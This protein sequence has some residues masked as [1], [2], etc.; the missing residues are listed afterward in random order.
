MRTEH[1]QIYFCM[2]IFF[3]LMIAAGVALDSSPRQL[4][5][6][7]GSNMDFDV[8]AS[9][10]VG[11][12]DNWICW[13]NLSDSMNHIYLQDLSSLTTTPV[14]VVSDSQKLAHPTIARSRHGIHIIWERHE[15]ESSQLYEC[16][17]D[18]TLTT[19][20]RMTTS[21]RFN[22]QPVV[23]RNRLVW[24]QDHTLMCRFLNE[25]YEDIFVDSLASNPYMGKNEDFSIIYEKTVDGHT[26]I[27]AA[28][29]FLRHNLSV[30]CTLF[31]MT[32]GSWCTNPMYFLRPD[33][34]VCYQVWEDS[35][36]K[37]QY[38][39]V[40]KLKKT[41]N[42]SFHAQHPMLFAYPIATT[43][44]TSTTLRDYAIFFD[45][46][47]VDADG[48]IFMRL[49][50]NNKDM[51]WI[52]ISQLAGQDRKPNWIMHAQD[53]S[54]FV[55]VLWEHTDNNGTNIWYSTLPFNPI[56][57][58]VTLQKSGVDQCTLYHNVPNPF[59]PATEIHFALER[60]MFLTIDVFNSRG[61]N[62]KTLTSGTFSQGHHTLIWDGRNEQSIPV[63][64]GV[65]Y[66]RMRAGDVVDVKR[67]VLLR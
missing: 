16:F 55:T 29:V 66:Y 47:T 40:N 1:A 64:N 48:D 60:P 15:G 5:N 38:G 6:V 30:S 17:Y 14:L 46:D 13:L 53:D 11:E 39:H 7:S 51:D 33:D 24:I 35:V 41:N 28:E 9:E 58:D 63:A 10:F 18:D 27:W 12:N 3:P 49:L 65:Y 2:I 36:W 59:N 37:I 34:Y 62:I 32:P 43:R 42:R 25:N 19:L 45:A 44:M 31:P 26:E 4:T 67:M 20:A 21:G 57:G 23:S 54:F 56:L 8:F 50:F 61:E 52:N 22:T